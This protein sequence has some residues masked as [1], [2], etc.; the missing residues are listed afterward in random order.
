MRPEDARTLQILAEKFRCDSA[1]AACQIETCTSQP[2]KC[3]RP[4]NL[5]RHL[6]Q[7]HPKEFDNLFPNETDQ[8][9]RAELEA[10][11]IKQDSIELV[12]INGY[13]F[14]VMEASGMQGFMKPRL[15]SVRSQGHF[16]SINRHIIVDE[17]AKESILIRE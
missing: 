6:L 16:F 9:K 10:F 2:L 12:T 7:E 14:S 15:Q 4:S 5:K 11:N 13:P 17:V 8:K 3:V 1:G